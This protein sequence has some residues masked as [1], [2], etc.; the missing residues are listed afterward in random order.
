M[1]NQ[2]T[3]A[4]RLL[5]VSPGAGSITEEI[6]TKLEAAFHDHVVVDFV[7]RDFLQDIAPGGT[8]VVAGGDG[9]IGFVVRML[10]GT[11][12]PLGILSLGTFNNFAKSLRLPPEIDDAIEVVR[13]GGARPV[14]LGRAHG[15]PFLEAAAIGLFGDAIKLGESAKDMTFG[16]I[17]ENFRQFS[18]AKAFEYRL[19]GDIDGRGKALSLVF[20]NTPS[21]G[22]QMPVAEA[23]PEQPYLEL[24]MQAGSSRSDLLGRV[25]ASSFLNKHEE[26]AD[27]TFKFS[28]LHVETGEPIA[29]FADNAQVG[30]TPVDIEAWTD[31]LQVILPPA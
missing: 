20:A 18:G 10:A 11:G 13:T 15:R 29:V 12:H 23:T 24:S 9:T 7:P 21:I 31:A 30:E 2:G 5:I 14:T 4:E 16:E 28:R 8:V 19:S 25:L 6:R 1:V 17:A 3:R 22:A 26:T 27:A